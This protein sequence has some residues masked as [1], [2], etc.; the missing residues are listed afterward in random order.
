MVICWNALS[1]L[2]MGRIGPVRYGMELFC[3]NGFPTDFLM[4]RGELELEKYG[5]LE[6]LN[7]KLK[8]N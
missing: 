8:S 6:V 5:D 3:F 2:L 7:Y 1:A 4:V